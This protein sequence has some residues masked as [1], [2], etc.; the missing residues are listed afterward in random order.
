MEKFFIFSAGCIRRGMD[1][2]RIKKYLE[3]NGWSGAN[4]PRKADIIVIATCGV[5]AKN[6][7]NSLEAV[8]KSMVQKRKDAA[9]IITGCLSKINPGALERIG[10]FY[11]VPN[12]EL[13]RLDSFIGVR[14]QMK[15]V[16][17][18]DSIQ[19]GGSLTDYLIARSFCRKSDFYK[20]LFD[21]YS[22][23]STF[24]KIS[25]ILGK[26]IGELKKALSFKTFS[27]RFNLSAKKHCK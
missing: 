4:S 23:N 26:L 27:D 16:S 12:G 21:R 3:V 14:I 2:I 18:P 19:D 5:V 17:Y 8:E 13:D 15:D 25:V 22:M 20:K 10:T 1:C 6:E 24:L 9:V 11:Y 7:K